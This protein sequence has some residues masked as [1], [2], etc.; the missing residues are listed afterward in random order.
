MLYN[1]LHGRAFAVHIF[2][3]R[4]SDKKER[5]RDIEMASSPFLKD[6]GIASFHS[7]LLFNFINSILLT[8]I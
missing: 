2:P 3:L 5:Q 7:W 6:S 1:I 4:A 8:W